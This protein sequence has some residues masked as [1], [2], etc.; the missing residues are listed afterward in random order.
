MGKKKDVMSELRLLIDKYKEVVEIGGTPFSLYLIEQEYIEEILQAPLSVMNQVEV[1]YAPESR[2]QIAQILRSMKKPEREI[3]ELMRSEDVYFVYC[4]DTYTLAEMR[5]LKKESFFPDGYEYEK[6]NFRIEVFS[7]EDTMDVFQTYFDDEDS[8]LI[9][10]FGI[11]NFTRKIP[12]GGMFAT[13]MEKYQEAAEYRNVLGIIVL[14]VSESAES[15]DDD[16]E[17][18]LNKFI[19]AF[20]Q[21]QKQILGNT[22][23]ILC[24]FAVLADEDENIPEGFTE[25]PKTG[26]IAKLTH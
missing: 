6:L 9:P 24:R 16:F 25:D 7:F 13:V 15:E 14:E 2:L 22:Q 1:F 12:L 10:I 21:I 18:S 8:D 17:D 5:R 20:E 26:L 23:P 3:N 11:K 19:P 4:D